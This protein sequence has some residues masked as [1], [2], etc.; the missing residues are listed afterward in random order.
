MVVR[1]DL[2]D[3]DLMLRDEVSVMWTIISSAGYRRNPHFP[4]NTFQI[5]RG[6]IVA[7]VEEKLGAYVDCL[8][9]AMWEEQRTMDDPK[10]IVEVLDKAGL[11]GA[12]ILARAQEDDIKHAL[13]QNTEAAVER[14]AFFVEN[15]IYFGNDK[16]LELELTHL[17]R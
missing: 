17:G 14:G 9:K 10:E 2:R 5:M 4:V 6:A 16:L 11:D 7:E 12:H 1:G 8:Y 13:I 15:E 3:P